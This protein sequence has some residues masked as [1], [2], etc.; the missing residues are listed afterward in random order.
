MLPIHG[1]H[2]DVIQ[3]PDQLLDEGL[4]LH[5]SMLIVAAD[6]VHF[7]NECLEILRPSWGMPGSLHIT[8]VAAG[9]GAEHPLMPWPQATPIQ[10]GC[11][12]TTVLASNAGIS[13]K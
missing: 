1:S 13:T 5:C 10:K 8:A 3:K 7:I 9:D 12:A 4:V 2:I 11:R 6:P